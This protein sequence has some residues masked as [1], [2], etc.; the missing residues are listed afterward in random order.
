MCRFSRGA[1]AGMAGLGLQSLDLVSPLF[2][3]S[4]MSHQLHQNLDTSKNIILNSIHHVCSI[5]YPYAT[6][7]SLRVDGQIKASIAWKTP[8]FHQY[9]PI[10]PRADHI[11]LFDNV[12]WV[13]DLTQ[14]KL[15]L[16]IVTQEL[17]RFTIIVSFYTDYL[18]I[19]LTENK[20]FQ[21][22]QNLTSII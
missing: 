16:E 18:L 7:T 19:F 13:A 1:E 9:T 2:N 8:S 11:M 4:S 21:L 5:S 20:T 12:T 14:I 17:L 10:I 6:V 22:V 3:I 15:D